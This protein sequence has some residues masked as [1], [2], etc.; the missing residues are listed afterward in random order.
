MQ[1]NVYEMFSVTLSIKS[2]GTFN[3][4]YQIS[5]LIILKAKFNNKKIYYLKMRQLMNIFFRNMFGGYLFIVFF[6]IFKII[7]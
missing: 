1:H 2:Y 6:K 5:C 3:K 7:F 4:K